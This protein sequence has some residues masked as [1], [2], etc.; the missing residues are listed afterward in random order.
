[1]VR[2]EKLMTRKELTDPFGSDEE[3]DPQPP[4]NGTDDH[5]TNSNSNSNSN[6]DDSCN[7]NAGPAADS[8]G[9]QQQCEFN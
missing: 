7:G 4:A 5:A 8:N 2:P 9:S 6:G 3:D 1:M